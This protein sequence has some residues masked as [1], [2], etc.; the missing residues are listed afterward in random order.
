MPCYCR[1]VGTCSCCHVPLGCRSPPKP[2]MG[3][4]YPSPGA[5]R[6]R[7]IARR[8]PGAWL[9]LDMPV[10]D[11]GAFRRPI[12]FGYNTSRLDRVNNG[13]I[14]GVGNGH[15]V[16]SV[17]GVAAF[18]QKINHVVLLHQICIL[19]R[20]LND[21]HAILDKDI[22]VGVGVHSNWPFLLR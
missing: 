9:Q 11:R 16:R 14:G 21:K 7:A 6:S 4:K 17:V 22:L 3:H 19:E 8:H 10:L 18:V 2:V 12:R 5:S 13:P 1:P 15:T 20:G